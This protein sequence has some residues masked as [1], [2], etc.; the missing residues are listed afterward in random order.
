MKL[1]N[2][3]NAF[4]ILIAIFMVGFLLKLVIWVFNL[5]LRDMKDNRWSG[6]YIKAYAGAEWAMELWLLKIKEKGYAINE[7]L[8][9]TSSWILSFNSTLKNNDPKIKYSMEIWT[10]YFSWSLDSW[11][12]VIIPLFSNNNYIKQPIFTDDSWN[13]IIWN[14]IWK[15]EWMSGSWNFNY[16]SNIHYK[17]NR[18]KPDW[19]TDETLEVYQDK[20]IGNFL[21]NNTWSYLMLFNKS[22]SKVHYILDNKSEWVNFSK[23]VWTIISSVQV[24]KFKQNITTNINNTEFLKM[25]KYSLYSK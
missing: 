25:L 21:T 4:S 1:K 23:P 12:T 3:K 13:N 14:I 5:M 15:W 17:Q 6:N 10:D 18:I 7:N 9:K 2:N 16:N 20:T 22:S 19:T 8:G 24:W 11:K